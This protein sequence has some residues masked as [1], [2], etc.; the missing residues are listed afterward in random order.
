LPPRGAAQFPYSK[1]TRRRPTATIL[2]L[3]KLPRRG[4]QQFPNLM[5]LPPRGAAQFPYSKS[6]R[7]RPTATILRL[8]RLLP[9]TPGQFLYAIESPFQYYEKDFPEYLKAFASIQRSSTPIPKARFNSQKSSHKT[10]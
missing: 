10:L 6:T 3:K 9:A 5:K 1:S 2:R 8:Y 7:R 4:A